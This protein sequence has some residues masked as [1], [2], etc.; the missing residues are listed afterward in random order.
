MF[1]GLRCGEQ[2]RVMGMP[3]YS[4]IITVVSLAIFTLLFSEIYRVLPDAT[5]SWRHL[6]LGIFVTALL[7]VVG[8]SLIGCTSVA[9]RR[10]RST[11]RRVR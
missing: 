9:R 3:L 5:I 4:S 10:V 6:V 1:D 8:K 2:P 7:F 11:A